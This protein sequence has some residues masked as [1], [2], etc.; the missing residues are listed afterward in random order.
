MKFF[1]MFARFAFTATLALSTTSAIAAPQYCSGKVT[2]TF[3]EQSGLFY[4][5]TT[6]RGDWLA[7]CNIN[8]AWQGVSTEICKS[9]QAT[10]LSALLADKTVI[11]YYT[12]TVPCATIPFYANAPAPVYVLLQK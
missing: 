6:F 12:D 4:V 9:W 7:I 3:L 8:T 2:H 5:N 1:N 11:F 10:V